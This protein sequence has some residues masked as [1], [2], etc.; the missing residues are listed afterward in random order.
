MTFTKNQED[1]KLTYVIEGRLDTN[2]SP[3]LN[4]DLLSS[5]SGVKDLTLD[6]GKIQYISSAG[7]RVLLQAYKILK[8]QGKLVFKNVPDFVREVLAITGLLEFFT[9]E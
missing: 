7:I 9:L 4:E 6:L 1:G 3:E 8:K 5:L 2:T